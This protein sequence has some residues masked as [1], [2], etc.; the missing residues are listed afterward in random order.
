MPSCSKIL[1]NFA[2]VIAMFVNVVSLGQV[3]SFSLVTW[4][5]YFKGLMSLLTKL[6]FIT[7]GP[8]TSTCKVGRTDA[9]R[10]CLKILEV[11]KAGPW[12]NIC[13]KKKRVYYMKLYNFLWSWCLFSLGIKGGAENFCSPKGL[14]KF[15][16]ISPPPYKCLW[17][18]LDF[19]VL[20]FKMS[21]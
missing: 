1:C 6:L 15:F 11:W 18:I 3:W 5:L 21:P 9:T 10:G 20:F 8:F 2:K 17:T 13:K 14:W 4:D 12:K 16:C 7:E 19:V